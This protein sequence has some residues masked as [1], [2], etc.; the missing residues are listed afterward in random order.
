MLW[1]MVLSMIKIFFNSIGTTLIISALIGNSFADTAFELNETGIRYMDS[2][3]Y[4]LAIESFQE[5]FSRKPVNDIKKNLMHSF[6][7]LAHENAE[8]G[9]WETAITTMLKA[10]NWIAAIL[11]S[12]RIYLFFTQ[13]LLMFK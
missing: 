8:L 2:H 10:A 6:A 5:A 13:T 11:S 7:A 1:L 3:D 12:C 4:E 9:N